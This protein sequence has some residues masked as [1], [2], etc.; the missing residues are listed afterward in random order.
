MSFYT[1]SGSSPPT[2]QQQI[3]ELRRMLAAL[4]AARL[5]LEVGM[6][7]TILGGTPIQRAQADVAFQRFLKTATGAAR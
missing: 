5:V 1:H 7:P 6:A 4:R 2:P 3:T